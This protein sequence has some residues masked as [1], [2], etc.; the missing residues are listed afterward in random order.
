MNNLIKSIFQP[1]ILL[2]F[3]WVRGIATSPISSL[4]QS[5]FVNHKKRLKIKF[6]HTFFI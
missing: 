5:K 4:K 6:T 2:N 3:A 1:K